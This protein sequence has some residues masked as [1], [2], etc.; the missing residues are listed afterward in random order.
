MKK[1]KFLKK[2]LAMLLA[3]MLVVAMIPLSAAAAEGDPTIYVDDQLASLSGTTYTVTAPDTTVDISTKDPDLDYKVLNKD[4]EE[5]ATTGIDLT[6]EAAKSGEVYTLTLRTETEQAED[7]RPITKDYTLEI[8]VKETVDSSDAKGM[9]ISFSACPSTMEM[10]RWQFIMV[11]LLRH[12][13][14]RWVE[15]S[16]E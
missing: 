4:S 10:T 8:T 13:S 14:S 15:N 3:V 1:S 2:S 16:R 6:K 5:I 9:R 11:R 12:F 7:S